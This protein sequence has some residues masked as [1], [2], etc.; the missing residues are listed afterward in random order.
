MKKNLFLSVLCFS[1]L[2][3]C[4][5]D[6]PPPA[7]PPSTKAVF[8]ANEGL[9]PSGV[10]TL[11]LYDPSTKMVEHN[12][13]QKANVY[14]AGAVVN[15]VFLDGNRLFLVVNA[16]AVVYV[17]NTET[18]VVEAKFENL[19]S[20]RYVAKVSEDRYFISDWGIQG[21]HVLNMKTKSINKTLPTGFGPERMLL[22]KDRMFIVNQGG[23]ENGA[24]K[25][26]STIVAYDINAD[27]IMA[28]IRVGRNPNS[29]VMDAE[30]RLWVLSGGEEDTDIPSNSIA[31]DLRI[32]NPGFTLGNR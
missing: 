17:I 21:V 3:G 8:I 9:F 12:I 31:A 28:T 5:D 6:P 24:R 2:I 18:H 13:F 7:E 10:G 19:G 22:Y 15:S 20:P 1:I 14:N 11:S 30:N 25:N 32:I 26:D 29:L 27:T 23:F 16:D 4:K